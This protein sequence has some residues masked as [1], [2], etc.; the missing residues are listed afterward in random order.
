MQYGELDEVCTHESQFEH[1][2]SVEY[3]IYEN[4]DDDIKNVIANHEI[5][6]PF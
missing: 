1:D 5:E 2:G 3:D 4:S 6:M